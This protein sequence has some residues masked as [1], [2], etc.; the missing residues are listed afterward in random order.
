MRGSGYGPEEVVRTPGLIQK[1]DPV[2]CAGGARHWRLLETARSRN[3][4]YALALLLILTD[5]KA[6]LSSM[7]IDPAVCKTETTPSPSKPP[8]R[9][10][11]TNKKYQRHFEEL[12]EF[13]ILSPLRRV[14]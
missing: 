4:I 6:F 10:K 1:L 13:G 12:E 14:P 3:V 2:R 7:I 8:R 11:F 5:E 9:V